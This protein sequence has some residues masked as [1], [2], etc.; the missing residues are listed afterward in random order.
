M[1]RLT[2]EQSNGYVIYRDSVEGL[3]GYE[4]FTS[5][6]GGNGTFSTMP[7]T[8]DGQIPDC[9][10]AGQKASNTPLAIANTVAKATN[11]ANIYGRFV[12]TNSSANVNFYARFIYIK[13]ANFVSRR[14]T[15]K[16]VGAPGIL[17]F[18]E[19][20]E[21]IRVIQCAQV[22]TTTG[23][24]TWTMP[25]AMP[26]TDFAVFGCISAGNAR[27]TCTTAIAST[28]QVNYRAWNRNVGV[29]TLAFLLAEWI[30]GDA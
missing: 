6:S 26:D 25:E 5:S 22:S 20:N 8:T 3:I 23:L 11:G 27:F 28:T 9:V 10:F 18:Y 19:E 15:S 24:D 17:K 4:Q 16:I 14:G 1:G 2:I 29:A 21:L 30:R 12:N 7:N 13:S